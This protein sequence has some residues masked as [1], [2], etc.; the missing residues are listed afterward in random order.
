VNLTL[1]SETTDRV[2]LP[3]LLSVFLHASI[4]SLALIPRP[5]APKRLPKGLIEVALYAPNR[6]ILPADAMAG[7]GGGGRHAL[8]HASLGKLP[9]ASDRQLVPPDPE[10]PKAVDPTLIVEPSIVAPQLASLPQLKLLTIGDPDGIPGPPSPG[11]GDGFGIGDGGGHGVGDGHGPGAGPGE[12]GGC[13]GGVF[14]IGGGITAPV[15][16]SEVLPE[17]SEDARKARFQGTVVLNTIVRED[18]SVQ[19]TKVVRGIGFGLDQ[20]AINAVLQWKFKPARRNGKP[21]A[22]YLNVEVS[23]NL[24]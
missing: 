15:L 24:R 19:V 22:A 5:I 18:G 20:N 3:R 9:R 1:L 4:I 16:V 17:Y 11:P 2:R 6:L 13:C 7:G 10:P 14:Q 12:D 8:T 23:F 21:V